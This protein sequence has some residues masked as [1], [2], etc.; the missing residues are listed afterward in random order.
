MNM[1]YEMELL[2]FILDFLTAIYIYIGL[3]MKMKYEMDCYFFFPSGNKTRGQATLGP[4]RKR[5]VLKNKGWQQQTIMQ[6]EVQVMK[7]IKINPSLSTN[8]N[9]QTP[10]SPRVG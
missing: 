1:K 4:L 3:N 10:L 2:Y 7:M 8:V 5:T 9:Y 6:K